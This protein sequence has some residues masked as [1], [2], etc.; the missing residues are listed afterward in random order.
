MSLLVSTF[1]FRPLIPPAKSVSWSIFVQ[2]RRIPPIS[3]AIQPRSFLPPSSPTTPPLKNSSRCLEVGQSTS[4]VGGS[5]PSPSP[6]NRV[7]SCPPSPFNHVL[8]CRPRHQQ[9]L[10]SRIRHDVSRSNNFRPMSADPPSPSPFNCTLSCHSHHQRPLP[11]RIRHG[12][13]KS[14]NSRPT[15]A[16]PPSPSPFIR[17]LS[18]RSRHQHPFPSKI[19][20][21]VSKSVNFCPMSVDPRHLLIFRPRSSLP[22]SFPTISPSTRPILKVVWQHTPPMDSPFLVDFTYNL[23]RTR[24]L[25]LI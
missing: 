4:S 9:P 24:L 15:S 14:D 18:C 20:R 12:V 17:V 13:S 1:H 2:R 3:L 7:L 21:K 23:C 16:D 19:P 11:S 10:P 25:P 6:F 22:L 8:S 5:T